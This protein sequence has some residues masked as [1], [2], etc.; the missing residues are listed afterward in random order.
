M[1]MDQ[2]QLGLVGVRVD[3]QGGGGPAGGQWD[4]GHQQKGESDRSDGIGSVLISQYN[5]C[6]N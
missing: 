1:V 5:L 2:G 6:R 4:G 3:Q